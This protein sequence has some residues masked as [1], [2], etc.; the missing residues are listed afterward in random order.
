MFLLRKILNMEPLG[1]RIYI[2][3]KIYKNRMLCGIV[4]II[5][6]LNPGFTVLII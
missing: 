4:S 1:R 5:I 2:K 3:F 6:H